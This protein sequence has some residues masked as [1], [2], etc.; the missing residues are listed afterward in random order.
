MIDD[1]NLPKRAFDRAV[2]EKRLNKLISSLSDTAL[3][4][5]YNKM[6]ENL[7]TPTA[8]EIVDEI[9]LIDVRRLN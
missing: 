5:L 1:K 3:D 2:K 8:E 4:N 9:L 7:I 6:V